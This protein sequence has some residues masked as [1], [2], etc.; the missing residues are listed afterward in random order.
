MCIGMCICMYLYDKYDATRNTRAA[1]IG[2][3]S[4]L[5]HCGVAAPMTVG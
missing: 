2:V 1:I 3:W 4:Y 5:A